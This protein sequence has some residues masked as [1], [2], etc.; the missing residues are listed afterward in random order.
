[1]MPNLSARPP[2]P[3]PLE[4]VAEPDQDV[5][6]ED[7]AEPDQDVAVEDVAEPDQDVAVEDVA[8]PDQDVADQAVA[9][10][11]AP[12][13]LPTAEA[14]LAPTA[15]PAAAVLSA[16][17]PMDT[18]HAVRPQAVAHVPLT[19]QLGMPTSSAEVREFVRQAAIDRGVDPDVAVRVVLSEGGVSPA[20][21]VGDHGSSFGPLQLHY[22]G[23][24][25]GGNAVAGLG[26]AFTAETHLNARDL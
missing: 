2:G 13:A 16:A 14:V 11:G 17:A 8:E 22:G 23:V 12:T 1:M 24:A 5:A 7:V 20:T 26:D 3:S 10:V 25:S 15:T 6:V 18:A 4:D 19:A 9:S 21:W